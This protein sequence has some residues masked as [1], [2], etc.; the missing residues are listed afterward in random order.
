MKKSKRIII[1]LKINNFEILND[2]LDKENTSKIE[3][4]SKEKII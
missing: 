1:L 3:N 4:N 2:E